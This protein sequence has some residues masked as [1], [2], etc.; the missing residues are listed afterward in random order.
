MDQHL[1]PLETLHTVVNSMGPAG[2]RLTVFEMSP[3]KILVEGE[4][5]N[6]SVA[7]ELFK[8]LQ[9]SHEAADITWEMPPPALQANSTARFIINGVRHGDSS[10]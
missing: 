4:A 2:A 1:Y 9:G 10:Q 3:D 7:T 5:A 8:A 6:V